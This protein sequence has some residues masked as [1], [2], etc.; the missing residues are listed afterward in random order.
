MGKLVYGT[1]FTSI[2]VDDRTLAH[3]RVVITT[4][5]QRGEP[6]MLDA[7]SLGAGNRSAFWIH[8]AVPVQ[9]QFAGEAPELNPAW[10]DEMLRLAGRTGRLSVPPEPPAPPAAG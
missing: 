7:G 2:G 9:F 6:F 4:K 5:L 8:P 10:I 3:L 1:A